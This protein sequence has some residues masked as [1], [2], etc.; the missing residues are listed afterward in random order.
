[1]A[2]LR[3]RHLQGVT[4]APDAIFR[5]NRLTFDATA[6]LWYDISSNGYNGED[7]TGGTWPFFD[8]VGD[9]VVCPYPYVP[10]APSGGVP[11]TQP[12]ATDLT[13]ASIEVWLRPASI[14]SH[15]RAISIN[16]GTDLN[17]L[18]LGVRD[19]GYAFLQVRNTMRCT[20]LTNLVAGAWTHIVATVGSGQTPVL[21]VNGADDTN[22][23]STST[24]VS[25][26]VQI[27]VGATL[28]NVTPSVSQSFQ[29]DIDTARVYDRILSADEVLRN[30]NA[31][32]AAHQ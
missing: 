10:N 6:G 21:Y 15:R 23:H 24:Y 27:S 1:M 30:Y 9:Y 7:H 26:N 4:A 25:E 29:G 3:N 22:T 8:G 14:G 20:G 19:V 5:A 2:K 32:R 31:G 12:I 13:S 28:Y 17:Y 18:S 11:G 16:S